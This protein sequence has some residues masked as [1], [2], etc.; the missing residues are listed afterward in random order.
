MFRR[1]GC[2]FSVWRSSCCLWCHVFAVVCL[3]HHGNVWLYNFDVSTCDM[4]ELLIEPFFPQQ[5]P[6]NLLKKFPTLGLYF[7]IISKKINNKP[8]KRQNKLTAITWVIVIVL[9]NAQTYTGRRAFWIGH[10]LRAHFTPLL[11]YFW[12]FLRKNIFNASE[13]QNLG[14]CASCTDICLRA[15]LLSV[16]EDF[17][18]NTKTL[19]LKIHL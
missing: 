10:I 2:G 16:L 14:L 19:G 11:I 8:C 5:H 17:I 4:R 18:Q 3:K 15:W 12:R 1:A 9:D 7:H 6:L 13:K